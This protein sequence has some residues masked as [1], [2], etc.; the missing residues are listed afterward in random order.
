MET[1]L[2]PLAETF[3][4]WQGE[5]VWVGTPMH[6]IRTAGCSVGKAPRSGVQALAH[7]HVEALPVLPSGKSAWSCATWDGRKFWC[8]T[9]FNKYLE[10]A[11]LDLVKETW[12]KHIC[13]TGGEPL[14]HQRKLEPLFELAKEAEKIVH[15]ETSGTIFFPKRRGVWITVAPKE[16]CIPEM[17]IWADEIKL[18]IDAKFHPDSLPK[19][20]L[21]HKTVFLQPV[22]YVSESNPQNLDRVQFWLKMFPHWRASVQLHKLLGMR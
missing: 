5:G 14:I 17:L 10:K 13:L 20:I 8:D 11:P 16:G 9:D 6:F 21:N 3:H 4:S 12:E 1:N 7:K 2:L 22:N 18:L 15:I 19:E